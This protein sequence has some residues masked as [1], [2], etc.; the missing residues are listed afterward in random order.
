MPCCVIDQTDT[1]IDTSPVFPV[2]TVSP[3]EAEP[4]MSIQQHQSDEEMDT[5]PVS[6]VKRKPI[7]PTKQGQEDV[8]MDTPPA[9]PTKTEPL[10]PMNHTVTIKQRNPSYGLWGIG[11]PK[12]IMIGCLYL[13]LIG[14]LV[15]FVR[16]WFEIPG[17]NKQ[18]DRLEGE[19]DRLETQN[20]R[21]EDLNNELNATSK[22]LN[23]S[24]T[25]FIAQVDDL[26]KI[27]Q[28]LALQ[29]SIYEDL[30]NEV[31]VT[32]KQLNASVAEL[33]AKVGDL[34]KLNQD[35]TTRNGIYEDLNDE[36]KSTSNQLNAS[37]TALTTQVD[38]LEKINQDLYS[39]VEFLNETTD[40]LGET[41]EEIT[42]YLANQ[43]ES[44]KVIVLMNL[45]NAMRQR[46][47][48]WDCNYGA[49]FGQYEWGSNLNLVIPAS[50][51]S[52]VSA[53]V[54]E[55]VLEELCLSED[56]FQQY[57]SDTYSVWTSRIL[58]SAVTGYSTTALD[59]YF[60][61]QGEV[62]LS[63]DEWAAASFDCEKLASKFTISLVSS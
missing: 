30:N 32:S 9:S 29:N 7:M 40:E 3:V 54:N 10:S 6:P 49:I 19:V 39:V 1:D 16:A 14:A 55:H 41:F 13:L 63:H 53:Y 56:D 20:G 24:V 25:E 61:E 59:W 47:L 44:N 38:D 15:Y 46:V 8:E 51:W 28:D 35:L 42:A 5:P 50:A 37:V 62:G 33:T 21:Y 17:L 43:I 45:E 60:P 4:I 26:E 36:L 11:R 52:E 18:V 48:T 27:N 2:K 31:S 57:L 58:F 23:S 22:Q 12:T 34:E